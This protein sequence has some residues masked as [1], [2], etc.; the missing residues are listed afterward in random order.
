MPG[1]GQVAVEGTG[2]RGGCAIGRLIDTREK[3]IVTVSRMRAMCVCAYAYA[4]G[5]HD[6]DL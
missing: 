3:N 1:Y 4:Y 5:R 6:I 2:D